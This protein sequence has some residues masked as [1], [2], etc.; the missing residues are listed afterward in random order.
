MMR[1]VVSFTFFILLLIAAGVIEASDSLFDSDSFFLT[2]DEEISDRSTNLFTEDDEEPLNPF[3]ELLASAQSDCTSNGDVD[4]FFLSSD[5]TRLRSRVV[6]CLPPLPPIP[7]IYDSSEFLNQLAP[8]ITMPEAQTQRD[9]DIEYLKEMFNLPDF[10][11]DTP[12]PA[13][14]PV[15]ND[16]ICP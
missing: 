12:P 10:N 7:N 16:E 1:H 5:T 14:I 15:E 6:E 8:Q 3:D 2:S 4:N 9:K 11:P 13:I